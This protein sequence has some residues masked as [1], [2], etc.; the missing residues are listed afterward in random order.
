M[1]SQPTCNHRA[2]GTAAIA[3]VHLSPLMERTS[4]SPGINIGL[5]DG[6]L[7]LDHSDLA[8]ARIQSVAG[9][10]KCYRPGSCACTHGTFIAGI[11]CARR[12]GPAPG[13]APGCTLLVRP[14]FPEGTAENDPPT[15]TPEVLGQSIFDTVRAGA[16]VIN[17]SVGLSHSSGD[18][19]RHLGEA[20]DYAA[21]KRVLVV[22]AA[23]NQRI[24][25]SSAI[26][27]HPWV[28]PVV[29]CDTSG[30]PAATSNLGR[31]IGR[32]G[33]SAPGESITSLGPNH[34]VKVLSGSSVA[35][36]FV[37]GTIALLWSGFPSAPAG[38]VKRSISGGHRSNSILPPLLDA[39]SAYHSLSVDSKLRYR[40]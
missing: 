21:Q 13:I 7:D 12:G 28:I 1:H 31:S 24:L 19:D 32:R 37:T 6:P 11:L 14:I 15:T 9:N 22:A 23:G 16:H 29:S 39:S 35:A 18:G 17:L 20:L 8:T 10:G 5:I 2:V 4:G 34:G 33:V 25:G 27:G 36:A 38:A 3:L 30:W 40:S 26:T